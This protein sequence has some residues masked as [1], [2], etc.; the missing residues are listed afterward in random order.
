[1]QRW[2]LTELLKKKKK[3]S[4]QQNT[5]FKPLCSDWLLQS[6]SCLHWLK[7]HE[8]DRLLAHRTAARLFTLKRECTHQRGLGRHTGTTTGFRMHVSSLA[9][10]PQ[11]VTVQTLTIASS[12]PHTICFSWEASLSCFPF[13]LHFSVRLFRVSR[14][15]LW[16]CVKWWD[17]GGGGGGIK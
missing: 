15:S 4:S 14:R 1:M 13:V 7:T 11:A 17:E 16:V 6:S 9:S 12:S 10:N 2:L 8:R 5:I 3:K